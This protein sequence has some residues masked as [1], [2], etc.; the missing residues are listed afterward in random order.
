MLRKALFTLCLA[1][2]LAGCEAIMFGKGVM[3]CAIRSEPILLPDSLPI[4]TIGQPYNAPLEVINTASPVHGIYVS[5][6]SPLPE[7]L[8]VEHQNRD[9][10]GS[11]TGTPVKAGVYEVQISAG[12]YG[13]QCVGMRA[14]RVYRLEVAE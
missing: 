13:T 1:V 5:D 9:A 2:P 6:Q 12:T 3:S 4:A 10:H 8:R 11:I 7:G 14:T